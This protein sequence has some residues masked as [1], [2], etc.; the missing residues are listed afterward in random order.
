MPHKKKTEGWLPTIGTKQFRASIS[1]CFLQAKTSSYFCRRFSVRK[2]L[3]KQAMYIT[4]NIKTGSR[5][6]FQRGKEMR[7][8]LLWEFLASYCGSLKWV[9]VGV[10]SELL[11][12][13]VVSYCGGL[14]RVIV[15]V[16]S[17]LFWEFVVSYC[18]S[19]KWV[20]VGVCSELLWGF[21]VLII[22]HTRRM[23]NILR[24]L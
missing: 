19:L 9:I 3:T 18:G 8:E 15:G 2:V 14:K 22:K 10:C 20:I 17:E 16:R 13:F 7:S 11:W 24:H 21:V 1:S 23:R 12:E 4:S 6:N 5:N